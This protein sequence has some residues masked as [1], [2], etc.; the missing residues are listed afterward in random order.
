VT[1]A[2][3]DNEVVERIVV[4]GLGA[5]TPIGNTATEFWYNLIAGKSGISRITHFDEPDLDVKIAG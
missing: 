2:G 1:G 5:V 4:T 3:E